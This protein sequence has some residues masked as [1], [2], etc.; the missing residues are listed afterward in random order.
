MH[1]SARS[2]TTAGAHTADYISDGNLA[3]LPG[4]D[5]LLSQCKQASKN[6]DMT[7][8]VYMAM[9]HA[10][11]LQGRGAKPLPAQS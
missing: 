1:G 8:A 6:S 5:D 3:G 10:T 7:P 2:N 11:E 4:Y 9:E